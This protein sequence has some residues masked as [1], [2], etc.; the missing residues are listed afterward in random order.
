VDHSLAHDQSILPSADCARCH[1]VNVAIEH[2]NRGLTCSICHDSPDP[3]VQ[4][5]ISVGRAGNPVDCTFCHWQENHITAH[6]KDGQSAFPWTSST[7]CIRCHVDN[8][9]IEHMNR[10]LSCEACHASTD[11]AVQAAISNGISGTLATCYNCHS[12]E[13]CVDVH[14]T[15]AMEGRYG[16]LDCHDTH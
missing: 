10:S 1:L 6:E 15:M 9:A 8:I 11:P 13:I 12:R 14:H 4:S 2:E 7:P 5:A 16:C 3:V